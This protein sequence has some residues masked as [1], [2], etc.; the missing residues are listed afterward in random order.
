VLISVDIAVPDQAAA[1]ATAARLAQAGTADGIFASESVLE[2]ALVAG[3]A[4]SVTV[5]AI[6][7]VP[8]VYVNTVPETALAPSPPLAAPSPVASP[9]SYVYPA[10]LPP[11][12]VA[13]PASVSGEL[14]TLSKVV[15][16]GAAQPV[17]RTY[18]GHSWEELTS[19]PLPPAYAVHPATYSLLSV[20]DRSNTSS[21]FDGCGAAG[22]ACVVV[23]PCASSG[24]SSTQCAHL[25]ACSYRL[26]RYNV[27]AARPDA[28]QRLASRFLL[29]S[30][31]GPTRALLSGALGSDMS[32]AA[33]RTWIQEQMSLP[34]TLLR[35]YVRR[36]TNPRI[37]FD[38]EGT[39]V[40]CVQRP[41]PCSHRRVH[42]DA[43]SRRGAAAAAS[44]PHT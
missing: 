28:T 9:A 21:Q 4:G 40:R 18:D 15:S 44:H 2:A 32:T 20:Y 6:N 16:S 1:T 30:T 34:P 35:S 24:M 13:L 33:V 37:R 12:P 3:G 39:L 10:T 36:A 8:T 17:A 43:S 11:G 7:G 38:L 31:F 29:Q 27:S 41:D 26:D 42:T 5:S 14:I 19:A 25:W 22:S 23:L